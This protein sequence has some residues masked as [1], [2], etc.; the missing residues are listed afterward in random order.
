[1]Q[2][3]FSTERFFDL[4]QC[5]DHNT[6]ISFLE[7][8]KNRM[9]LR[10]GNAQ[11]GLFSLQT[12][13]SGRDQEILKC[14]QQCMRTFYQDIKY[15]DVILESF[16]KHIYQ[17]LSG[18]SKALTVAINWI[19][20]HATTLPVCAHLLDDLE[21]D[22]HCGSPFYEFLNQKNLDDHLPHFR[23]IEDHK[24][25]L[26]RFLNEIFDYDDKKYW[27]SK[28]SAQAIDGLSGH[29]IVV[30]TEKNGGG[31]LSQAKA[32]EEF[33]KKAGHIIQTIHVDQLELHYDPL[34]L[35]NIKFEDGSRVSISDIYNKLT[36]Q[37]K[38]LILA[39]HLDAYAFFLREKYPELYP[40]DRSR[41][42][43]KELRKFQPDLIL[44]NLPYNFPLV[45]L[46]YRLRCPL[47]LIHCD[48]EFHP[49]ALSSFRLQQKLPLEY[50]LV[51]FG[52]PSDDSFI[53]PDDIDLNDPSIHIVGF[54]TRSAFKPITDLNRIEEIKKSYGVDSKSIVYSISRGLLG[55]LEHLKEPIDDLLNSAEQDTNLVEVIVV[56]GENKDSK[57][58]L[59]CY[60]KDYPTPEKP[61]KFHIL[62]LQ[63]A[64]QMNEIFQI[65]D[66]PDFKAG[67]VSSNEFIVT[68]DPQGCTKRAIVTPAYP[69]EHCNAKYLEKIGLARVLDLKSESKPLRGQLIKELVGQPPIKVKIVDWKSA[70]SAT[71][72]KMI[73]KF[74]RTSRI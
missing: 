9:S 74:P 44:C 28:N 47:E 71:I 65:S 32:I 45:N 66:I 36:A 18:N 57:A 4:V 54:P 38:E 58:F 55:A 10:R 12:A 62:G 25:I 23:Q 46:A 49:Y 70:L 51:G 56:C 27:K 37:N 42:L 60:L 20:F 17:T 3:N 15:V 40:Y 16:K 39:N 53:F 31:H 6:Q 50:R 8:V 29:K 1:M 5:H 7:V 67:G 69:W 13:I 73:R 52:M 2:T 30:L 24:S 41:W 34:Y 48:Y 35:N 63:N 26:Q 72:E 33:L 64:S 61:F 14:F 43:M 68:V 59:E 22:L 11:I 19:A 21:K